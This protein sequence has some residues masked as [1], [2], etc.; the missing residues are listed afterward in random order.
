MAAGSQFQ[1]MGSVILLSIATSVFN[2]YTRN[3]IEN[4]LAG[5]G[6]ESLFSLGEALHSIPIQAQENIRLILAEGY[7]RQSL[8]ICG[9]SGMP[10][11]VAPLLWKRK[12]IRV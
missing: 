8:V 4:I 5:S 6:S 12:Q 3:R 10:L 2:G 11:L 1:V 7:N 9:A